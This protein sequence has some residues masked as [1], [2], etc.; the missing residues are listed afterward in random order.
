M[1]TVSR[2]PA[3]GPRGGGHEQAPAGQPLDAAGSEPLRYQQPP[4]LAPAATSGELLT[5]KLRYKEPEGDTSRLV[6]TTVTASS[7]TAHGSERLRFA[8]AVAGFGLLL[9]ESEYRGQA[10]WPMV[11]ELAR[12]AKGRDVEGYRAEFLS[13]AERAAALQTPRQ[14]LAAP[15]GLTR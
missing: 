2:P 7:E 13:L 8:A 5:L 4:A 9:R 12:A 6:T 11:L 1:Y 3:R 14:A 15:A 10:S